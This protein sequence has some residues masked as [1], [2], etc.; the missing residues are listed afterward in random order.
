MNNILVIGGT[1]TMGKPLVSALYER[2]NN[3]SVVVRHD[4]TDTRPIHYY[5][6]NAKD[7]SFMQSVLNAK[8]DAIIDFCMYGAE[9]FEQCYKALLQATNQYICLSSAAVYA[10]IDTPKDESAPRYMEIDPPCGAKYRWYC[11]EKARIEDILYMSKYKNWTIVRPGMTMGSTHFFWGQWIDEEWIFRI[12]HNK[13][14]IVPKDMLKYK[15]SIS[16]GGDITPLFLSIIGNEKALGEIFNVTST[17]VYSW[18][19]F[20]QVWERIVMKL[21]LKIKIKYLTDSSKLYSYPSWTNREYS[22]KRARLLDRV[23]DSSKAYSLTGVKTEGHIQE[24]LEEWVADYIKNAPSKIKWNMIN[25]TANI[26]KITHEFTSPK[27]FNGVKQYLRYLFYR[28]TPTFFYP[29]RL[30]K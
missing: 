28:L 29:Y 22:Y 25:S 1:G 18:G 16:Y 30:I 7:A 13:C 10:D 3:L 21:G 4:V 2:G 23:F 14:V 26:D 19:D 11:Y 17:E 15:A 9:E 12:V 5:K 24:K 27:Y 6:G 20:L 8:Y